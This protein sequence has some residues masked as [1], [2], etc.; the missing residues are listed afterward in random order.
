MA[1]C[2][3]IVALTEGRLSVGDIRGT[4]PAPLTLTDVRYRDPAAGMDVAIAKLVIDVGATAALSRRALIE[5]LDAQGVTVQ[6][7]SVPSDPPNESPWEPPLDFIV[8]RAKVTA[9]SIT[10]MVFIDLSFGF[11]S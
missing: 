3:R 7:T 2:P 4:L 9:L 6:L 1:A 5:S 10:R 8:E 11:V